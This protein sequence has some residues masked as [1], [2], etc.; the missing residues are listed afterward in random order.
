MTIDVRMLTVGPL[1]ENAYLLRRAGDDRALLIDPGDEADRLLTV[2]DELG[3][4]LEAI[5]LTHTHFDHVGAV[6]PVARATGAPVYVPEIEKPILADINS[7]VRFPGFGP[8]EDWDAEQT[9]A[10]GERLALAGLDI[11]V[12]FTPGH[13]PGHVSYVVDGEEAMF[14]G[15]VLFQGSVGRTDL[16]GADWPTLAASIQR[17]LDTLPDETRVHPGH[18][19]LTTLGRERAT[20]PFLAELAQP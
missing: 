2:L 6:A 16:P 18:M 17:L 1:Q 3:V 4:R 13:S 5:L 7:Y 9:V 14:S 11:D 12:I 20:N 10:G 15:D 8:F 19:G